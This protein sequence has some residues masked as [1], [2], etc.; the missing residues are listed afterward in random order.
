[1]RWPSIVAASFGAVP[2]VLS[3]PY[4]ETQLHSIVLRV[5]YEKPHDR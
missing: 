1:M 5:G 4:L 3:L 2:T